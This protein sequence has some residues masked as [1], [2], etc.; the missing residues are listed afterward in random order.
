M[1]RYAF[2]QAQPSNPT[3][4]PTNGGNR[5]KIQ[6]A[7]LLIGVTISL[8]IAGIAIPSLLRSSMGTNHLAAV[9]LHTLTI[10]R[11]T[12]SYTFQNIA[13]AILGGLFGAAV[14]LVI[15]SPAAIANTTRIVRML[16]QVAHIA[17]N[18]ILG[19]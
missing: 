6:K 1:R 17:H 16:Q 10:A 12:F 2:Q 3:A 18:R 7:Q 15:N 8:F 14:A 4:Q 5:M 11:V 19:T 13:F 9:S